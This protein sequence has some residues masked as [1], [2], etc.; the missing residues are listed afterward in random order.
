[1]PTADDYRRALMIVATRAV[2][3]SIR[4]AQEV[5]PAV[6][7]EAIP[8]VIGYYS[9]GTAALAADQY[10]DLREAAEAPGAFRSEPVINIRDEQVRRGLIWSVEPL[11]LEVPDTLTASARLAE[12]VQLETARPFRDTILTNQQRDP[13][14]V[15]WKRNTS[16]ESCK[17][18]T[19]LADRGA[20]YQQST[21]RFAT[22]PGCDCSAS[23]VFSSS[24]GPEA[25]ALQ[26]VASRRRKTPAQRQRL[27]AYLRSMPG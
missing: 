22:H 25:N 6:I 10:D 14:S 17:M 2:N 11:Y 8:P 16:G 26:Y 5:G 1:M 23:A 27:N 24:A 21:A 18:C 4:L 12:V 3:D 13:A 20:V 9:D 15:G 19:M 7:T